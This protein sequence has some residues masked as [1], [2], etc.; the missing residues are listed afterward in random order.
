MC[1]AGRLTTVEYGS[2]PES[3][4]GAKVV[5]AYD[6]VD[7]PTD[8]EHRDGNDVLRLHVEYDWN[9]D[10]TVQER[11]ETEYDANGLLLHTA[12]VTF[13]YDERKRLIQEVRVV[14]QSVVY[15]L[16][17][18]YDQL[19]NRMRMV[20]NV[21][22]RETRYAYDTNWNSETW[23]EGLFY[24]HDGVSDNDDPHH[25]IDVYPTRNNRLVEYRVYDPQEVS[26]QHPLLRTVT[27]TYFQT[28]HVSH[29]MIKD[30]YQGTGEEPPE[31]GDWHGLEFVYSTDER[32]W[33]AIWG[34]WEYDPEG[35]PPA[36][37]EE[38]T[39]VWEFRFDGSG[40]R[41]YMAAQ[42]DPSPFA[43]DPSP[44]EPSD[45]ELIEDNVLWTDYLGELP[46]VDYTIELDE[47]DD[48]I[49]YED[50]R[51]LAALGVQAQQLMTE[52]GGPAEYFH[53][54]LIDSTMLTSDDNG[55]V[56]D[57]LSYTAFGDVVLSDGTVGGE[58]PSGFPRY[59]Y[60]GGY[61]YETGLITLYGPS[62]DLPPITLQHVGERWYQPGIGRFIQRDPIGLSGGMNV[63][64]YVGNRPTNAI[65][66]SGLGA[67]TD[68]DFEWEEWADM[69]V[70]GAVIGGV[71]GGYGTGG[72]GTLPGVGI[73][74]LAG[75]LA[76]PA[77]WSTKTI[78]VRLHD[79][80]EGLK[81]LRESRKA[82]ERHRRANPQ[83][84]PRPPRREPVPAPPCMTHVL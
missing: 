51:Y 77:V 63:Y 36:L 59:G 62:P 10:N 49:A 72:S 60:A 38:I 41:R 6:E 12:I 71:T 18:E 9:L 35:S 55:E 40:R 58:L 54:D 14:D 53:G 17:Y 67:A 8:I 61:G 46:Y 11:Q 22:D 45:W 52:Q 47:Y 20:D 74:A 39:D 69:V 37:F 65:D 15:D 48:P 83:V 27:Y 57:V 75:G 82:N 3:P 32:L 76:Y 68:P 64:A 43:C 44:C 70:A 31:Y 81:A 25:A 56:V 7:R 5:Y 4:A 73:G 26:G 16:E 42:W 1:G 28:G 84:F 2:D 34:T 13:Y 19:G 80:Y 23:D 50:I 66:P 30:E 78:C 24:E 33:L 79:I 21:S 29:I